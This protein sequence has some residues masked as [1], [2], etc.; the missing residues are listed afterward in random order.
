MPGSIVLDLGR[1]NRI[2][3]LDV[4]LGYCVIEPRVGLF[5]LV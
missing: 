4:G 3:E 1:M 2:L 5:D